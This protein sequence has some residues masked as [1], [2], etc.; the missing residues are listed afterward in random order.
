MQ[1]KKHEDLVKLEKNIIIDKKRE[2]NL[3]KRFSIIRN[4]KYEFSKSINKQIKIH[5][6]VRIE[7]TKNNI[8]V[9]LNNKVFLTQDYVSPEGAKKRKCKDYTF[10]LVVLI[11]SRYG[12][13]NISN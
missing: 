11:L 5:K 3:K 8:V 12:L 10:F 13:I 2:A 7:F 1:K 6:S 9:Y 4:L